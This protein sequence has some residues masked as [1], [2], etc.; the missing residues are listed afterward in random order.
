MVALEMKQ[1]EFINTLLNHNNIDVNRTY[2]SQSPLHIATR[3]LLHNAVEGLLQKGAYV[4]RVDSMCGKTA[5][6]YAVEEQDTKMINMLL[7][8]GADVGFISTE[9][10]API[11][12]AV[13]L[14]SLEALQTT[15]IIE[16]A[17]K[18][19][20]LNVKTKEGNTILHIIVIRSASSVR[21]QFAQILELILRSKPD[22]AIKNNEGQTA[23][24]LATAF[25]VSP[26]IINLLTNYRMDLPIPLAANASPRS[27]SGTKTN[28]IHPDCGHA[29][30]FKSTLEKKILSDTFAAEYLNLTKNSSFAKNRC[31][32]ALQSFNQSKNRNLQWVPCKYFIFFFKKTKF[33]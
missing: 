26:D 16:R 3:N 20:K 28:T 23:L 1:T 10:L 4:N 18:A 32:A 30:S 27:R 22:P 25:S 17:Q 13:Q 21:S 29:K 15:G 5:L 7:E 14:F 11:H 2:S 33:H 19:G 6:H 8:K 24:S 9:G 31:I 12:I